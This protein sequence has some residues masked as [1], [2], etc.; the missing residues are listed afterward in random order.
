MK[1]I[2]TTHEDET[3][4]KKAYPDVNTQKDVIATPEVEAAARQIYAL[5][6]KED[7]GKLEMSRLRAILMNALKGSPTLKTAN[8]QILASWGKGNSTTTTDWEGLCKTFNPTAEQIAQYTIGVDWEGLCK[9]FNPT[10]D[11]IAKFT[12]TSYGARRFSIELDD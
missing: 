6:K 12:K 9:T 1:H 11:V 3:K 5:L 4:A 2:K 7:E 8:G 10:E